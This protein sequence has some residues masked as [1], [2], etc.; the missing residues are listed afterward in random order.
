[1]LLDQSSLVIIRCFTP[2]NIYCGRALHTN[3]SV[4]EPSCFSEAFKSPDWREAMNQEYDAL[5]ANNTWTLCPIPA[6]RHLIQNKWVYKIKQKA[7]GS[8]EHYKVHLVA[9]GFDQWC[10]I[11]Y[12]ETFS[13]SY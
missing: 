13:P 1:M 7:N 2:L 12:T 11:D 9:K 8:I 6:N 3:V 5:L 10:G 4:Q